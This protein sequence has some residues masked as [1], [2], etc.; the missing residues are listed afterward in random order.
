MGCYMGDVRRTQKCSS[1]QVTRMVSIC[2]GDCGLMVRRIQ[3]IPTIRRTSGSK[4]RQVRLGVDEIQEVDTVL[5]EEFTFI[6]S[7]NA[8]RAHG[9]KYYPIKM[10]D[11]GMIPYDLELVLSTWDE[12]TSGKKPHIL[13]TIPC[14]QVS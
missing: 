5:T 6:T 9:A 1:P 12:E 3:G 8:G 13:Y 7:L 10:D 4:A 2:W 14:G 11:E